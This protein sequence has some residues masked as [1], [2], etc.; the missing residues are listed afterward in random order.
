M[1]LKCIITDDEPTAREGLLSYIEKIDFLTVVGEC[2]DAIQLNNMLKTIQPELLFLDIEMPYI[3]G[4]KLLASLSNP[5]KVIITTAYDRYAI[6]GYELDVVD[7]LLKPISFERFLKAVN[8]AHYLI[9]AEKEK[10]EQEYIF[11]KIDKQFKKVQIK[12]ILYIESLEN[13]VIIHTLLSK[14]IV[15]MTLKQI[16]DSLPQ[17]TFLQIH[18]SFIV[19]TDQIQG[20]DGNM[21]IIGPEKITIARNLRETVINKLLTGK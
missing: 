3:S 20:I 5:P 6:D 17:D 9:T 19:N 21:L 11:F 7:Y 15:R 2:E 13:Y 18:R 10:D 8:K 4:L 16:M 14:E 12:D 1:K